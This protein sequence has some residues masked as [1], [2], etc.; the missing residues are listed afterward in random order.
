MT[1]LEFEQALDR[2]G[3]DLER[4]PARE[5]EAARALLATDPQ[6]R[7]ALDAA[8]AVDAH[9]A[10][11]RTHRA[12]SHLAARIGTRVRAAAAPPDRLERLFGWLTD[13]L[14]RPAVLAM[15]IAGAGYLTGLSVNDPADPSLT[16][17]VM[18]LAFSDIY[19]ELENAEP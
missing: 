7:R 5:A 6:A 8:R 18:T 16:E 17:D 11:L 19:A 1:R 3:A 12:P 13:R 2:W 4:W 15:L 9:L 10:A 14:W